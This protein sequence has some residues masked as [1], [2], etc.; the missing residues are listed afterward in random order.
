MAAQDQIKKLNDQIQELN[1]Q[2]GGKQIKIFDVKELNEAERV[3]K[4]LRQELQDATNDISGIASGFKN[5]V[6]EMQKTSKPLADAKKSF[7]AL[8]GLAQKDL[9]KK[10]KFLMLWV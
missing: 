1:K 6:Q 4:S 9:L 5:V 10:K 2:L 7:N 3:I 8:S